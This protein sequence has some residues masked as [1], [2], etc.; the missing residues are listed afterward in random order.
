MW[1]FFVYEWKNLFINLYSNVDRNVGG[2]TGNAEEFKYCSLTT[3][4]YIKDWKIQP[5]TVLKSWKCR[6]NDRGS[7]SSRGH[8]LKKLRSIYFSIEILD[9]TVYNISVVAKEKIHFRMKNIEY[10]VL[11][12]LQYQIFSKLFYCNTPHLLKY[13]KFKELSLFSFPS[14][15]S[16]LFISDSTLPY[17]RKR[18]KL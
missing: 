11:Y 7:V 9:Q 18:N 15:P 8:G 4:C 14:F 2:K 6:S 17:H 3:E 1:I 12:T 10:G 13:Y 5:L 16:A